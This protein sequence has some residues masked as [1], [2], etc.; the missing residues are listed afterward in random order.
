MSELHNHA[1]TIL[2]ECLQSLAVGE[3][4]PAELAALYPG[5]EAELQPSLEAAQWL[6]GQQGD[7]DLR[8]GYL[9]GGR[10]RLE[11]AIRQSSAQ[12]L[13]HLW[14][15]FW[16]QVQSGLGRLRWARGTTL[17]LGLS[18]AL[19][20]VLLSGALM[21]SAAGSSLPG[22]GL[23]AVKNGLEQMQLATT[24]S[25]S[26]QARLHIRLSQLR[27]EEVRLLVTQRRLA[28]VPATL[29]RMESHLE[30]AVSLIE[31]L[32]QQYPAQATTLSASL[33]Q[34]IADNQTTF[35]VLAAQLPVESG[36]PLERALQITAS[37]ALAVQTMID[38]SGLDEALGTVVPSPGL[39]LLVS[40]T[41]TPTIPPSL[42]WTALPSATLLPSSTPTPGVTASATA[43]L[44]KPSLTPSPTTI[45]EKEELTPTPKPTKTPKVK[46]T[47]DKDD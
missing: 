19:L 24:L 16:S 26:Q 9:V 23:Y 25:P 18:M 20:V 15:R 7:F 35:A 29:D 8:P 38:R 32:V 11:A 42:T 6:F 44:P 27:A 47:K 36:A 14:A 37:E 45:Q 30:R 43:T 3:A 28:W 13:Q 4:G 12:T 34:A 46:P 33:A 1:E 10:Q 21:V 31:G 17:S 22:D 40:S 39:P 41:Q 5:L 2:Q